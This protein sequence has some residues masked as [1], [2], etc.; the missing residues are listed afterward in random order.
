MPLQ[1]A[2]Q[3]NDLIEAGNKKR[4]TSATLMNAA[5]SRSHA[6]VLLCLDGQVSATRSPNWDCHALAA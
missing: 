1:S 3:L 4:A 6:V 5:S 2:A